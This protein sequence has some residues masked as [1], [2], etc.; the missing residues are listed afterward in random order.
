MTTN[1]SPHFSKVRRRTGVW[2]I[3]ALGLSGL[4]LV[5]PELGYAESSGLPASVQA[6]L[7]GKLAGYDRNFAAR[8]G[9][10]AIILLVVMPGDT[11]SS[12]A[13]LEVKGALSRLSTVGSLPHEEQVVNFSNA[14]ALADAVRSRKAAIVYFGPGFDKQLPAIR[15]AFSSLDVLTIG[16]VP[17][18]VPNGIVLGFD[19]VSGHPK[20]LVNVDQAKKQQVSIPASVLKLMKVFP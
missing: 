3:L 7:M 13:A 6:E 2:M 9:S 19:L 1:P 16:S 11:D 15:G 4:E 5:R 20:L 17:D 14:G 12:R 8:A 18:Y 10:K